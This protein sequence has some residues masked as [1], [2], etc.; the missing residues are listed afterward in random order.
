MN[1]LQSNH[2]KSLQVSPI[3]A[4]RSVSTAKSQMSWCTFSA[5]RFASISSAMAASIVGLV[6]KLSMLA[7]E[8]AATSRELES[9]CI[10]N[11]VDGLLDES[12][13]GA[14]ASLANVRSF[15]MVRASQGG[16]NY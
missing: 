2:R 7:A 3:A 4:S 9:A 8:L 12:D 10:F 14:V 6:A 16:E 15:A 1:P 5:H 11:V 13:V